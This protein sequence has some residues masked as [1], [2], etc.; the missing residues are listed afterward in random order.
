MDVMKALFTLMV[1]LVLAAILSGCATTGG[2]AGYRPSSYTATSYAA[3]RP[4]VS[5][6][7]YYHCHHFRR[8]Q[9]VCH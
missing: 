3:R 2:H 4:Y 1:A 5:P 9:T 6:R 7:R 8:Y